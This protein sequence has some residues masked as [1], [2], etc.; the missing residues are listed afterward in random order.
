MD[1]LALLV[2]G[3]YSTYSLTVEAFLSMDLLVL[4]V[5]GAYHVT[6]I[7]LSVDLLTP[8]TFDIPTLP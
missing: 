6:D 4:F 7:F 8:S 1:L 2:S 3:T 5:S